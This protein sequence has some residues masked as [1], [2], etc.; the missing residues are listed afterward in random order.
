MGTVGV[1]VCTGAY[2]LLEAIEAVG[3]DLGTGSNCTPLAFSCAPRTGSGVGTCAALGADPTVWIIAETSAATLWPMC[4]RTSS[5]GEGALD[6]PTTSP[7]VVVAAVA[8]TAL[9]CSL[10]ISC[11]IST[12]GAAWGSGGGLP[13][14]GRE[15]AQS[16][17]VAASAPSL[18][19][20]P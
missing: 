4:P 15:S 12:S 13:T 3:G 2:P 6:I 11:P 9:G 19:A 10:P 8:A 1:I 16:L 7:V 20:F 14:L 18:K 5:A 17:C